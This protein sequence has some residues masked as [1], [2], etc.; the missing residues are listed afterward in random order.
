[1][2][3]ADVTTCPRVPAQPTM[4]RALRPQQS[5]TVS[6]Q[7]SAAARLRPN[8]WHA[9]EEDDEMCSGPLTFAVRV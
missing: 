4:L 7:I 6:P 9:A 8:V 1:M 3:P 5:L 2:P